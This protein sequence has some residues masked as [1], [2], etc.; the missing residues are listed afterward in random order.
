MACKA[1]E[2]GVPSA[3]ASSKGKQTYE[4]PTGLSASLKCYRQ[5]QGSRCQ[6]STV[7]ILQSPWR[8]RKIRGKV[9]LSCIYLR[10]LPRYLPCT[11]TTSSN[12]FIRRTAR[13]DW[14]T[15]TS[16]CHQKHQTR[17]GELAYLRLSRTRTHAHI[18][19]ILAAR[20]ATKT[21]NRHINRMGQPP[22]TSTA[23]RSGRGHDL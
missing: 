1:A 11:P 12:A 4:P 3:K 2:A 19:H 20:R 17:S 5:G 14:Q 7:P 9:S 6:W 22:K 15:C 21:K 8:R 23:R 18:R 13:L 10:Y 16:S